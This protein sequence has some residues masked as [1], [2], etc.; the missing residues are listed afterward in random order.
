[1]NDSERQIK[2]IAY[3]TEDELSRIERS[4]ESDT[5]G[6]R[7]LRKDLDEC[8]EACMTWEREMMKAV[9]EDGVGSVATA[10]EKLKAK[11]VDLETRIANNQTGGGMKSERE[12]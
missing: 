12:L 1:M 4:L 7:R 2:F 11:I 5:D 6:I 3:V 9:G 8:H 10:I